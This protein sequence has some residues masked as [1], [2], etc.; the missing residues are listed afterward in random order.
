[1][2]FGGLW[3]RQQAEKMGFK[4]W[5]RSSTEQMHNIAVQGPESR[6]ILKE[7]VWTSPAQPALGE[8][9]WFRF[10]IGRIGGFEGAP[11]VVSRTGYTGELGYEIFCHPKDALAVFDA[12][13]EAGQKHGLKPM[14]LEALDMVR[15]EAGLIFANYE[16]NDQTDPFEAGIGFTVPLKSKTDDF[17]GSDGADRAQRSSRATSWSASTSIPTSSRPWRLRACWPRADRHG[18]QRL[19]SPILKKNIALARVDVTHAAAGTRV[20]IGK[21]DG[22]QKRLPAAVTKFPHY[23]PEKRRVRS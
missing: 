4:A 15:I 7:I 12:V 3:L 9:E 16:F 20:E 17:I 11:I 19:R 18:H 5:V 8:L 23:D 22:H 2:D 21:L 10:T 14:G 13:W 6:D 1:M